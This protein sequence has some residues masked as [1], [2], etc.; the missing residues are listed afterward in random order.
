MLEVCLFIKLWDFFQNIGKEMRWVDQCAMK[1]H[2][3]F[4]CWHSTEYDKVVCF[5]YGISFK[6]LNKSIYKLCSSSCRKTDTVSGCFIYSWS[7]VILLE[8]IYMIDNISIV[9]PW[10]AKKILSQYGCKYVRLTTVTSLSIVKSWNTK[11]WNSQ[12]GCQYVLLTTLNS[13]SID[14]PWDAKR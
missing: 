1:Y 5:M 6:T 8:V 3:K 12:Y 2:P 4:V 10:N 9:K 11:R 14:K 7:I 13:L